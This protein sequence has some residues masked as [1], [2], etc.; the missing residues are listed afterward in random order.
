MRLR[1]RR[2]SSC[3]RRIVDAIAGGDAETAQAHL[4]DHLSGTLSQIDAIRLAH[5]D[6]FTA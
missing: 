2:R 3:A 4:R 5:P 1:P 6:Y